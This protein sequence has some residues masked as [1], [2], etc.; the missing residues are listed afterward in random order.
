MVLL[1][2]LL[3]VSTIEVVVVEYWTRVA[4]LVVLQ[5]V[6]MSD[7]NEISRFATSLGLLRVREMAED[8]VPGS[9]DME[10]R[11]LRTRCAGVRDRRRAGRG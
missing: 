5:Q 3:T 6:M 11:G 9:S 8:R 1:L 7:R 2:L 4:A 10:V